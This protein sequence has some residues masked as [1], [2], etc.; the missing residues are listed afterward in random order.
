MIGLLLVAIVGFGDDQ[1]KSKRP[2]APP[3][4]RWQELKEVRGAVLIPDGWHF[5]KTET[6]DALVFQVTKESLKETS[7]FL[8]GLTINVARE[9]T[10]KTKAPPSIYAAALIEKY[11]KGGEV[12]I[13]PK[14]DRIGN[15]ERTKCEVQKSMPELSK[16]KLFRMRLVVLAND[17]TDTIYI[18]IFGAPKDEWDQAW[19]IGTKLFNPIMIN[20]DV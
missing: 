20:T 11:T 19:K 17:K 8:T 16:D 14:T 6:K 1:E 2:E 4:F 7:K 10:K 9:V 18:L 12:L 5:Q 15:I 3:G 13:E